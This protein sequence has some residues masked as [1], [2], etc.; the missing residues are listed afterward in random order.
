MAT[1]V[2][3]GGSSGIGLKFAE[4]LASRGLN[5]VLVAREEAKLNQVCRDLASRS[6]ASGC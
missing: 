2:I 4:E 6:A 5:L 1:A 3:T